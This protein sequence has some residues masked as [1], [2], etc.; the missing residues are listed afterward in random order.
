MSN[1]YGTIGESKPSYLLARPGGELISIPCKP[2]EGEITIGT[3]MYRGSDGMYAAADAE[4]AVT[5]EY[6]AVL[7]ET[8]DTS[9]NA[10]IAEDAK[11][12]IAGCFIDGKVT[13]KGG[14]PLTDEV[15]VVLRKQ[16]CTFLPD[17]HSG[18]V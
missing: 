5:T 17:G 13:L 7:G 12:Y 9:A 3:L 18:D 16:N 14:S 6:L 15:K 2:N 4:K 10:E 1:L 8:V 11:A